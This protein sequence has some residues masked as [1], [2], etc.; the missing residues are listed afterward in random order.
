LLKNYPS[1]TTTPFD[2]WKAVAAAR[3]I[4]KI[5]NLKKTLRLGLR[6]QAGIEDIRVSPTRGLDKTRLRRLSTGAWIKAQH[7]I[8]LKSARECGK[9]YLASA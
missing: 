2:A 1:A 9:T 3:K 6:E 8:I 5:N 7:N 4:I